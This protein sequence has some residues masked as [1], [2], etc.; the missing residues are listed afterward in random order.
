MPKN[1]CVYSTGD[2]S[3]AVSCCSDFRALYTKI[4]ESLQMPLVSTLGTVTRQTKSLD[5]VSLFK[6]VFANI[7]EQCRSC[8][9][10]IDEVYVK[11]SLTYRGGSIFGYAADCPEKLAT[12]LLCKMVKCFFDSKTFLAK[13][14]PCHALTAAFQHQA[15]TEVKQSLE[16][17]GAKVF[18]LINDNNRFNQSFFKMSTAVDINAPCI[19][20]SPVDPSRPLFLLFDPVHIFKNIRNSWITEKIQTIKILI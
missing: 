18:G 15:V 3:L 5:D 14:L 13:I 9:L 12:T 16:A 2:I 19:V 10:I 20:Q 11:A 8:V 7:E 6:S 4:R 17:S 1:S